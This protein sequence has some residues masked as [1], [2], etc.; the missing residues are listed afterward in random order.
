M[1][2]NL[3][4]IPWQSLSDDALAGVIEE[5]VTREGTDYGVEYSLEEKCLAVRRQL[6]AGEALITFDEAT[7]TCSLAMP[8]SL[9]G[10]D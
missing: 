9:Q 5:F 4:A 1:V 2:T 7:G 3:Q 8:D 10:S 6:E